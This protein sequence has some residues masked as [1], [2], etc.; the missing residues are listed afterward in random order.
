MSG[1]EIII[2]FND[3][4]ICDPLRVQ[5]WRGTVDPVA[6][7][8]AAGEFA[9]AIERTTTTIEAVPGGPS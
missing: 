7:A 4:A 3:P 5:L 9:V 8:L 2:T 1:D 6:Q